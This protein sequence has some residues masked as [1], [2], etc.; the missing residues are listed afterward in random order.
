MRQAVSASRQP[1]AGPSQDCKPRWNTTYTP[2]DD[3]IVLTSD[4]D[5]DLPARPWKR[6]RTIEET[7]NTALLT[8]RFLASSHFQPSSVSQKQLPLA[9][10]GNIH[11]EAL[12]DLTNE[13]TLSAIQAPAPELPLTASGS[14][15]ETATRTA[16]D[17]LS[18]VLDVVPDVQPAHALALIERFLPDYRDRVVEAV[19]P[20]LFEESYPKVERNKGKRKRDVEDT[21]SQAA[22]VAKKD[23]GRKDRPFEG[24]DNYTEMAL[25][26]LIVDFPFIPIPHVRRTLSLHRMLYAPAF[27]ALREQSRRETPP[28]KVKTTTKKRMDKGKLH[29]VEFENERAWLLERLQAEMGQS[30]MH[31]PDIHTP[32]DDEECEDGIQCGCCF[33][34]YA[35]DKMVQCPEAHLFCTTCM[36]SYVKEQLGKH[37]PNLLCM[38]ESQCRLPFSDSELARFLSP[39]LLDLYHRVKQAKEIEAAGLDGLEE[40]PFCEYKVVIDNPQEK[41]FR[42]EREECEAV[43]CRA[44]KKIDHLPKSCKEFEEENG[45]DVRHRVEEAMTEALMRNCPKCKRAFVKEG[46]CNKM[47]CPNCRTLSCYICREI[48]K[49]YEHFDQRP[50]GYRGQASSS[51]SKCQLWDAVEQ[52]HDQEV[53]AA[54]ERAIEKMGDENPEVDKEKL[55][56]ELLKTVS[57][58]NPIDGH[59]HAVHHPH[60]PPHLPAPNLLFGEHAGLAGRIFDWPQ[61]LDPLANVHAFAPDH[62]NQ[63]G[64]DRAYQRAMAVAHQRHVPQPAERAQEQAVGHVNA[65]RQMVERVR[66]RVGAAMQQ[67]PPEHGMLARLAGPHDVFRRARVGGIR[68]YHL[69]QMEQRQQQQQQHG[70]APAF[71]VHP[72]ALRLPDRIPMPDPAPI[73]AAPAHALDLPP[74]YNIGLG[75]AQPPMHFQGMQFGFDNLPPAHFMLPPPPREVPLTIQRLPARQPTRR[76]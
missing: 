54:R 71:A 73:P 42:C 3:V 16:D 31:T 45:L 2:V 50:P 24:G 60:R 70:A 49:G 26:Q 27:L 19:V 32:E 44:C 67:A 40:C 39:K 38:H 20:A 9:G 37:D 75:P 36:T 29:D 11:N 68:A 52:R 14:T 62:H 43:S 48:I 64:V 15:K 69:Q 72:G 65:A 18:Q 35:F 56:G 59:V 76:R 51:K 21:G 6:Q 28:Y 53:A 12:S 61:Q 46:G 74:A 30:S 23:Y 17:Y 55:K 22:D 7:P 41:L 57:V 47:T 13:P 63:P 58:D 34:Q 4:S 33:S 1:S 25:N 5:D 10:L 8:D 66:A